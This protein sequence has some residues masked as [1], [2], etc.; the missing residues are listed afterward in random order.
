MNAEQAGN[1]IAPFI[2][3][4]MGQHQ[5]RVFEIIR[6]ACNYA[7]TKG[8]W[9]GMTAEFF[10]NTEREKI[11]G[12]RY[13]FAPTGYGTLLAVN[14]DR[15]TGVTIR[16]NYFM[17]H[18]NGYGDIKS[19]EHAHCRWNTDVYDAGSRPTMHEINLYFPEGVWIGFRSIGP[20]GDDEYITFQGKDEEGSVL[21][22]EEM[23]SKR[24]SCFS[25]EEE[26]GAVRTL[27]GVKVKIS[28]DFT[29]IDNVLFKSIDHIFKTR[30]QSP[31]EV[32]II[33]CKKK[34][35]ITAVLQP[36]DSES[37]YRKYYI[38][39]ACGPCVHALFKVS[40][41]PDIIDGSQP[42]IIHDDNALLSLCKGIH[43]YY[44]KEQIA[45]GN[46]FLA[47]GIRE[48]EGEKRESESPDVFPI[49]V[50]GQNIDDVNPV[51]KYT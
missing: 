42:I 48:L 7:W 41:Q 16:D 46:E 15:R 44:F 35:Y 45:A 49:Q 47:N 25:T 37:K 10:V 33:D 11:G 1:S 21:S 36:W 40:K 14:V 32:R 19:P 13:M 39:D 26:E 30:T 50:I 12:K 34:T 4:D 17:F 27:Q 3:S 23:K 2:D 31:I 6:R 22:Y 28:S 24:C 5:R 43:L 51:L 9:L 18:R 8:K 20:A 38:P 29:Y